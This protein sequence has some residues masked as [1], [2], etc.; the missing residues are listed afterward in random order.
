M[1]Q[2]IVVAVTSILLG[3][4]AISAHGLL[5]VDENI[6]FPTTVYQYIGP[7]SFVA[8]SA[9]ALFVDPIRYLQYT[10]QNNRP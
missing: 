1:A 8:I 7:K 2:V 3:L 4:S 10:T 6:T 9:P 5:T